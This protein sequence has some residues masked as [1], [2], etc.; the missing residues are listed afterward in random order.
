M[1]LDTPV[2]FFIFNRPLLTARV[3]SR[4]AQARPK[5]LFIVADGPRDYSETAACEAARNVVADI[6]WDCQVTRNYSDVNLGCKRRMSS[7]IDWVFASSERA[8]LLEDDCLPDPTFFPFCQQMLDRYEEEERVMTISGDNFQFG[9]RRT[10]FSYYFSAIHHIWGWATWR[11]AWQHYDV[12]MK[13]WP[14]IAESDFPGDTI[15]LSTAKHQKKMMAETHAGRLDTWDYQWTFTCWMRQALCALPEVNLVSN[16][17]YGQGATHCRK[18]DAFAAVP[19]EPISFPLEHPPKVDLCGQA[20]D[21]FLQRA[22]AK[23]A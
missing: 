15:P 8:I 22:F 5:R 10:P 1:S 2:A 13:Q 16:I 17:G 9:V 6:D 20:D 11:R 23:A 21:A 18:P 4:I 19:T 7:G 3:F 12:E 14:R